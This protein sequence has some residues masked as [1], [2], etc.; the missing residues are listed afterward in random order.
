MEVITIEKAIELNPT[1]QQV[2]LDAEKKE[3]ARLQRVF[4]GINKF[5]AEHIHELKA[6]E[7]VIRRIYEL[8]FTDFLD[9]KI[10]SIDF[11]L[12]TLGNSEYICVTTLKRFKEIQDNN[13][14]IR[15]NT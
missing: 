5:L 14:I 12:S 13:S 15:A 10:T 11:L 2:E 7:V 6:G 8:K 4:E 3:S 1:I 9:K